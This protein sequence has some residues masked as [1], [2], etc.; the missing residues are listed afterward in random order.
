[1]AFDH[2]GVYI[3]E[4]DVH[5]CCCSVISIVPTNQKTKIRCICCI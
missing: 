5:K 3:S 4:G 2:H 1:M